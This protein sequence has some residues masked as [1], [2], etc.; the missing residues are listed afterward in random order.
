MISN[1]EN[2]NGKLAFNRLIFFNCMSELCKAELST[3][4][5]TLYSSFKGKIK[6]E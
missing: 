1:K 4:Y 6:N 2:K 5:L 3:V